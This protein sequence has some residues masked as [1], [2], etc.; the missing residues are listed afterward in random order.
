MEAGQEKHHMN[1]TRQEKH[2]DR[3][4]DHH[5]RT[6]RA[7]HDVRKTTMPGQEKHH[8]NPIAPN[9]NNT[10]HETKRGNP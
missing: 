4:E 3:Q 7:P 8:I 6:G 2:H 9:K 10:L 1:A 5:A